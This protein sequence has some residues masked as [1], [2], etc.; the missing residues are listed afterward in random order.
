MRLLPCDSRSCLSL[1]ALLPPSKAYPDGEPHVSSGYAPMYR[2]SRCKLVTHLSM[3]RYNAI[4]ELT[5]D[6]FKRLNMGAFALADL[7]GAGFQGASARDLFK[8]GL[9]DPNELFRLDRMNEA[10]RQEQEALAK[11]A[12]RGELEGNPRGPA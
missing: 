11:G 4:P 8:A 10:E 5:L 7:E 9:W 3:A 6:D 1:G 2:C 12:T